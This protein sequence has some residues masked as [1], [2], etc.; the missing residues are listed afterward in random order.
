MLSTAKGG[1]LS[2]CVKAVGTVEWHGKGLSTHL[3]LG[4]L[5]E[6]E[7]LRGR[8]LGVWS[9]AGT[10]G[11]KEQEEEWGCAVLARMQV[12]MAVQILCLW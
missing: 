3:S 4:G 10:L 12:L 11:D 7:L 6:A 2:R 8:C 1:P 9:V 5:D